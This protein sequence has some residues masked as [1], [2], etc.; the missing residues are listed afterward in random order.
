METSSDFASFP[1][2][3]IGHPNDDDDQQMQ[4]AILACERFDEVTCPKDALGRSVSFREHQ[5]NKQGSGPSA[6][7]YGFTAA[8]GVPHA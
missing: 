4:F 5:A 3:Q 8:W 6:L 7:L 1:I 2:F